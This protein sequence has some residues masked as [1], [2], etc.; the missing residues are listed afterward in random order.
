MN[1][2]FTP[3]PPRIRRILSRRKSRTLK[4]R[5]FS[6]LVTVGFILFVL[7]LIITAVAFGFFAR[8]LPSPDKLSEKNFQQSTKIYDRNGAL[9]YILYGEQNR[10]LVKLDKIPEDLQKA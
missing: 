6:G 9:L 2:T 4:L 10:T 7:T 5:I 8:N 1:P 3:L